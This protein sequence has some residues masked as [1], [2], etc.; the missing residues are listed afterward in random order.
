MPFG[1]GVPLVDKLYKRLRSGSVSLGSPVDTPTTGRGECLCLSLLLEPHKGFVVF[2]SSSVHGVGILVPRGFL[3]PW[4]CLFYRLFTYFT[5]V[6]PFLSNRLI[7]TWKETLFSPLSTKHIGSCEYMRWTK[8]NILRLVLF[9]RLS[10][11]SFH[12]CL[13][14]I[15][16]NVKWSF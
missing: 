3:Y 5:S 12:L 8:L 6:H 2:L 13:K 7:C 16:L 9:L 11:I 15:I 1:I 14:V 10:L 4:Y